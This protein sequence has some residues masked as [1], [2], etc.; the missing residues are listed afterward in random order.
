M[1]IC[2]FMS[3]ALKSSFIQVISFSISDMY[4]LTMFFFFLPSLCLPSVYS[5]HYYWMY[6]INKLFGF[7][8]CLWIL[9]TCAPVFSGWMLCTKA[10]V[11]K[12]YQK[13]IEHT[14]RYASWFWSCEPLCYFLPMIVWILSF[15]LQCLA[16]MRLS[17]QER[18]HFKQY[19]PPEGDKGELFFD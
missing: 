1:W 7:Y 4:F 18:V 5:L 6:I 17:N 11:R 19:Q 16:G 3:H 12:A 8:T 9:T 15:S 2:F 10:L 14:P 13:V